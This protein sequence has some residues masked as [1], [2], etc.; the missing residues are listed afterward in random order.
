MIKSVNK[1]E[2]L[3]TPEWAASF[4]PVIISSGIA[5]FIIFLFVIPEFIK[6]NKVNWELNQLVR[7]KNELEN[8][9]LRYKKINQKFDILNNEKSR[10]INLISGTSNLETLLANL[11]IIGRRNNI[12]FLS[13]VPRKLMISNDT[14]TLKN[15]NQNQN[16]NIDSLID[17]LLVEGT[18]KYLIDVSFKTNFSNLQS[19]LRDIEFQENV[20]L[21]QDINVNVIDNLENSGRTDNFNLK[22]KFSI[23]FYGKI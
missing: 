21:I 20:V 19:F 22:V 11:G 12:E 6:S 2:D 18:K 4:L 15:N 23:T 9:K 5:I 7:K 14:V 10:I 13:I 17:P 3:I 8:L 16:Q 1:K